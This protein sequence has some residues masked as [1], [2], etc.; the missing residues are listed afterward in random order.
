[1]DFFC[2]MNHAE[3]ALYT[4]CAFVITIPL[5]FIEKINKFIIV[6]TLCVVALFATLGVIGGD[7]F[8]SVWDV[9]TRVDK[10]EERKVLCKIIFLKEI[11]N[12]LFFGLF[13]F[14]DLFCKVS[15][16]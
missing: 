2:K 7:L 14:F 1:M 9:E 11:G 4:L 16:I 8:F 12:F 5:C 3:W 10:T 15:Q 13:Q 6:N